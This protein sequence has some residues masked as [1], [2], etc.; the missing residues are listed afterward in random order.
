MNVGDT[1]SALHVRAFVISFLGE[2]IIN[3]IRF[4]FLSFILSLFLGR[5][6]FSQSLS[7]SIRLIISLHSHTVIW[8]HQKA[9]AKSEVEIELRFVL[10]FQFIVTGW[11]FSGNA[12]WKYLRAKIA[13]AIGS[14]EFEYLIRKMWTFQPRRMPKRKANDGNSTDSCEYENVT[15]FMSKVL[16]LKA[17]FLRCDKILGGTALV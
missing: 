16:T 17:S 15:F 8:F 3:Q 1:A 12:K 2:I 4:F 14:N 13:Q 7:L 10:I 6:D 9:M 11:E 5:C